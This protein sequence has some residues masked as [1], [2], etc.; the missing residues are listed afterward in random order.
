[1]VELTVKMNDFAQ[2]EFKANPYPFYA[3]LRAEAPVY[4]TKF[5]G[6]TTWLVTRYADVQMVFKDERFVKDWWPKTKWLYRV[7]GPTIRHMLNRDGA[8]HTRLRALV[9]KAFTPSLMEGLRQRIQSACDELLS[10]LERNGQMELMSGFALPLP[11][12]IISELLG[13]P[14]GDRYR[15][16]NLSRRSLSASNLAGTLLSLPDQRRLIRRVRKLI[17]DRR[18]SPREDLI[19]ALVKA[20]EAGDKLT[21]EEL[22]ATIV[23]LLI[24][25]YETTVNLIG[26]GVL[27]LLQHPEQ[28]RL[29]T[30][31]PTVVESAI[32]EL[33]RFTSPLDMAS[34]RFAREELVLHSASIL[35][36]DIVLAMVGSANHDETQFPDPETFDIRRDPNRHVAFGQGVHFCIGAPLARLEGQIAMTTLFRRFPSLRLAH[37]PEKLRWR[38]SLI[39]RGLEQLPVSQ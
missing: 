26:N 14:E 20:E 39:V 37:E 1:M 16:H 13:I 22:V 11:L 2:P 34:Q 10:E 12:R 24:A 19:S 3:R 7:S 17:A 36:G 5:L 35:P 28:R 21:E 9:H 8:D 27:A 18:A 32:E 29:F 38:K 31:D 15:L 33:L 4:R 30:E 6:Q 23:L 25:G